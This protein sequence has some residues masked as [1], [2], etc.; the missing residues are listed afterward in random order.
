LKSSE[1]K[2]KEDLKCNN[3]NQKFDLSIDN[4]NGLIDLWT[5]EISSN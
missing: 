3:E 5:S 4:V 1:T 2:T